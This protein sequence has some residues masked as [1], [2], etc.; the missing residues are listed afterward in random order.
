[1]I[2]EFNNPRVCLLCG[3]IGSDMV[4]ISGLTLA[5]LTQLPETENNTALFSCLHSLTISTLQILH[6][7][8]VLYIK[9]NQMWKLFM[10][11]Y[12]L[13]MVIGI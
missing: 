5:G 2:G 4:K 11:Y 13:R 12:V 3:G 8:Y 10:E 6:N 1:M 9:I 7:Q